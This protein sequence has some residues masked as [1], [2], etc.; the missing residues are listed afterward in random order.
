MDVYLVRH[1]QTDGNAAHRHQH[2][3]TPLNAVGKA[4]ALLAAEKITE[5]EPTLLI[6]STHKRALQTAEIISR[7]CGLIA[8]THP[9]FEELHQSKSIVGERLTGLRALSNISQWF[10]GIKSASMHDGETYAAFVDRLAEARQYLEALPVDTK[11]VLVSHSIF[12]NFFIEHM[13]NPKRMGLMRA[14][15]RFIHILR[16]KNSSITHV[17]YTKTTNSHQTGWK[18]IHDR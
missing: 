8:E 3:D 5:L 17:Q 2:T 9:P 12:I 7:A 16:L 10:F 11:V 18:I 1:G 14:G 6:S 13:V 4:Q 15:I